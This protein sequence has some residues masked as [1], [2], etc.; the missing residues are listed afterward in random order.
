MTTRYF[1]IARTD[2]EACGGKISTVL[3]PPAV[4]G[5][6][7]CEV[8]GCKGYTEKL[9][10]LMDVIF[11]APLPIDTDIAGLGSVG[12]L[13]VEGVPFV[14]TT[15]WDALDRLSDETD[16]LDGLK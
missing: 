11:T 12:V 7:C 16:G 13:L 3:H 14:A 5:Q 9:V 8:C 1:V 2:C 4:V 6:K 10:D 15:T